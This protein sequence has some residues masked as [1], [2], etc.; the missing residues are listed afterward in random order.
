MIYNKTD[1]NT[2]KES[3]KKKFNNFG[4]KSPIMLSFAVDDRGVTVVHENSGIKYF[5]EW[6][7]TIPVKTF[8]HSIKQHLSSLHYPRISKTE[9]ITRPITTEEIADMMEKG[10]DSNNIPTTITEDITKVYMID[11]ILAM[12][13]EFIL[14]DEETKDQYCYRMDGSSIF[15]LKN[16]RTGKF[17]SLEEAGEE[18]FKKSHLIGKLTEI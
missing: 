11:K 1:S 15:Y 6:D 16:Y 13:D 7:F 2:Y 3:F 14:I 8:I 10:A 12:K 17:K 9:T 4:E 5:Y 18:F